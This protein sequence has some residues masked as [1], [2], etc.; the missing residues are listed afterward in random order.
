MS[1]FFNNRQFGNEFFRSLFVAETTPI[2]R[3]I[4]MPGEGIIICGATLAGYVVKKNKI[5]LFDV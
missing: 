2:K 5:V 1:D 3:I 4:C